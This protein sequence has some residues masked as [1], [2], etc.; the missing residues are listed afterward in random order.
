M[1]KQSINITTR[2]VFKP[3][4]ANQLKKERNIKKGKDKRRNTIKVV[5]I[6]S[7]KRI[8]KTACP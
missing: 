6:R 7:R 5:I 1:N 8:E 2:T 3:I 4:Y